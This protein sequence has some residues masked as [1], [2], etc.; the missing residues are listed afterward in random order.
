MIK[1]T[2]T[3]TTMYQVKLLD[4]IE[5]SKDVHTY[6]FEKP[7]ELS[8]KSGDHIHI[9]TSSFFDGKEVDRDLVRHMSIINHPTDDFIGITTRVPGSS[10]KFKHTMEGMS[11]DDEMILFKVGSHMGLRRENRPILM[12]SMG[13]GIATFKPLLEEADQDRT[14]LTKVVHYNVDS[15]QERIYGDALESMNSPVIQHKYF[16]SREAFHERL[17]RSLHNEK[18]I[19]YIVGSRAFMEDVVT[20][21]VQMG[22]PTEDIMIDRKNKDVLLQEMIGSAVSAS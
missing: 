2:S 7:D 20:R 14:G 17:W 11:I 13:V 21:A 9:A 6:K 4:V 1:I 12:V 19:L 15:K 22:I 8:W 3:D 10:S 18:P 16:S 5:E